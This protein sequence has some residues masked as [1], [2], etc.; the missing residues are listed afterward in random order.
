MT[1]ASPLLAPLD[2]DLQIRRIALL[3][4]MIAASMFS[5]Y[6]SS[7][8]DSE[9]GGG[10]PGCGKAAAVVGVGGAAGGAKLLGH[11][12]GAADD[13]IRAGTKV[14]A[15]AAAVTS[16]VDDVLRVG[17]GVGDDLGRGVSGTT[18][19]VDAAGAGD[20]LV[21]PA[22]NAT[23]VEELQRLQGVVPA[24]AEAGTAADRAALNVANRRGIA[25]DIGEQVLDQG[26]DLGG[27]EQDAGDRDLP[28]TVAPARNQKP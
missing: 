1:A 23:S 14:G 13:V 24:G 16:P 21:H 5:S 15:G 9:A 2:G 22:W 25:Q 8:K 4:F 20:H 10:S 11:G 28:P 6:S 12:C 3:F 19:G 7:S 18:L 17:A 26:L 27:P